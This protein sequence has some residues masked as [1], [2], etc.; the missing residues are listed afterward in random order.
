MPISD[1]VL[2]FKQIHTN[3]LDCYR[4]ADKQSVAGTHL[5]RGNFSDVCKVLSGLFIVDILD[6]IDVELNVHGEDLHLIF[7]IKGEDE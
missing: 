3:V 7:S 2:M 1:N 4:R 6:T 5:P